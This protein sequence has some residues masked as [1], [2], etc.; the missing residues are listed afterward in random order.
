[1]NQVVRKDRTLSV[2]VPVRNE[3]QNITIFCR[4]ITGVLETTPLK[5]Q[6]IF[7]EDSSTDRTVERI[8]EICDRDDRFC[9]IFLTRSF[10]HHEAFTAGIEYAKGDLIIMM[11]G[12]LQHPPE[13]IPK[14]LEVYDKGY[15]MVYARRSTKQPFV[16]QLGSNIINML[17]A[18][19]SDYPIDLTSSVFRIFSRRA[20]DTLI[21]M[22][23]RRRFI[24]GMLSWPGFKTT[25]ITFEEAARE[26][27]KTKYNFG[28]MLDLAFSGFTSFSVKPLRLGIYLG[29][30]TSSV[31]FL[32]GF[33]YMMKYLI[34]GAGVPG[35]T[36]IVVV[37]FFLGGLILFVLGIIGEYIGNIFT[38][39]K[40]RPL[41]VVNKTLNI[42]KWV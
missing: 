29:F 2:I 9:A 27:G 25:A 10:G 15:D 21:S 16:K 8:Y 19:L 30:M 39:I 35:F 22:R 1:M 40:A 6:V 32:I 38:E 34:V 24:T 12:D 23:E 5:W 7:V 18:L 28:R 42:E 36:S 37:M 33:Y 11:D 17:M 31:S 41:Y 13:I 3:E 4:R 26:R 14:L 20:A